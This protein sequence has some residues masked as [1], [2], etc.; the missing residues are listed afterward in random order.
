M[1]PSR[2]TASRRSSSRRTRIRGL[3]NRKNDDATT[4]AEAK[5]KAETLDQQAQHRRGFRASSP[6]IIPRTRPPP[7]S[8]G[9]LGYVP[10]SSLNQSDPALKK[11][12]LSLKPGQVS[13]VIALRDS[14]RILKLVARKRPASADF[15]DPAVQQIDSRQPSTIARN[16][17]CARPI[18]PSRATTPR[19]PTISRSRSWNRPENFP[20]PRNRHC[21]R[22]QRRCL[23]APSLRRPQTRNNARGASIHH[24]I[25]YDRKCLRPA[26]LSCIPN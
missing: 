12:V 19:S 18:W 10:E 14:Y 6:W 8:G 24:I 22:L 21:R 17:C 11:M 13:S 16:S 3:R 25:S 20:M 5:R 15:N 4:D 23:P 7:R 1:W 26:G 9:D 2:N